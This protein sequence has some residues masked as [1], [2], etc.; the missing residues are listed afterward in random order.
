MINFF[1]KIRKKLADDNKPLKYMRYAIGEILLVV[2]G[3]LIALQI[4][5]W[6]EHQKEI[7]EEQQ[8]LNNINNEFKNN[9]KLLEK[10]Q[11]LYLEVWKST[12]TIISMVGL[13]E[14]ELK[15]HNLDSLLSKIIDIYDFNP[16]E[17]SIT[18]ILASGKLNV[19]S[20]DPLKKA[21][22]EW[23]AGIKEKEDAWETLDQNTQNMFLPYLAKNASLKNI[24]S[25]GPLNWN[26]KSRLKSDNS[27]VFQD[28]EFENHVDN[29][30]WSVAFYQITLDSLESISKKIIRL[31]ND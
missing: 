1:R 20:S 17:N 18:E 26:E 8:I 30:A 5:N 13:S 12:N 23:S 31:T 28:I 4:N 27:Q 29:H 2:V 14:T 21:L 24:D 16:T 10:H 19:I 25:Y 9:H 7:K 11:N 3:I 6:N 15:K 22:F